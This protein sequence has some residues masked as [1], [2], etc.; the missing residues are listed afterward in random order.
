MVKRKR[1]DLALTLLFLDSFL[2]GK[3]IR[4]CSAI[5][6]KYTRA[7]CKNKVG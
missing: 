5:R 6:R 3:D 2:Q 7:K 4:S 1:G